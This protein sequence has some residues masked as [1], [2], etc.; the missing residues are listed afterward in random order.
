MFGY[1]NANS[2][3]TVLK[4]HLYI[5]VKQLYLLRKHNDISTNTI[6]ISYSQQNCSL[7]LYKKYYTKLHYK[8]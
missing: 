4:M 2:R 8:C 3:I 5:L 1:K 7:D 6:N